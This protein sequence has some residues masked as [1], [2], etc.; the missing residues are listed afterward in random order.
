LVTPISWIDKVSKIVWVAYAPTASDPNSGREA[1]P[2]EIIADLTV[3]RAAGFNGLV[4]YASTGI[5]GRELPALAQETGFEGL[6]MGIWD[7]DSQEEYDA[8]IQAAQNSVVLGYSIGNEGFNSPSRYDMSK[9]SAAIQKLREATM[10]PVTTTEE[11]DD[12][13]DQ[14]L[15]LTR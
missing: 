10:K 7:P 14:E 3:L 4:T 15:L 9:L 2:D 1:T 13:Y 5:M 11:I 8:A 6:I 12:Y